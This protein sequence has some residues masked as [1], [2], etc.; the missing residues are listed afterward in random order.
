MHKLLSQ[1]LPSYRIPSAI[2][3][4]VAAAGISLPATDGIFRR[5]AVVGPMMSTVRGDIIKIEEDHEEK[6]T[7]NRPSKRNMAGE[8]STKFSNVKLRKIV[9]DDSDHEEAWDVLE[10]FSLKEHSQINQEHVTLTSREKKHDKL[11]SF[12]LKH[13]H[14]SKF[15]RNTDEIRSRD[16]VTSR[17]QLTKDFRKLDSSSMKPKAFT[18]RNVFKVSPI[19]KDNILLCTPN[20]FGPGTSH[21]KQETMKHT[22]FP[23]PVPTSIL[24]PKTLSL[25][26]QTPSRDIASS[27]KPSSSSYLSP[28]SQDDLLQFTQIRSWIP[29]SF[30]K[31][32][33]SEQVSKASSL[34]FSVMSYNVLAQNLLE[35]HPYL[36]RDCPRAALGWPY[37]W[38]GIK[39]EILDMQPDIVCL[40]EVQFKNPNHFQSQYEPF[41]DSL[42]YKFALKTRTGSKDDGCVIFYKG[43]VFNLEETSGLEYKIDRISLLDRDN[44]GLVCRLVPLSSPTT[45][46]VIGTT[47]LLYNP[48]R[49]D[50][51]LCQ[52]A[53]F[54][55]ELDRLARTSA[56]SYL[57]TIATG[58]FNSDPLSPVERLLST[59]SFHYEG[60]RSGTH[61][62]PRKLLPDSLGLSDSCQWEVELEQRGLGGQFRTGS[63]GFK[64]E[65]GLRS[66]YPTSTGV[67]TFQDRWTMVDYIMYSTDQARQAESQLKLVARLGLPTEKN[68]QRSRKIPSHICPSDH[69][70]LMANFLLSP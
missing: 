23:L 25:H 55:A 36:Y 8:N 29:T 66:V 7:T 15:E 44:I 43:T 12:L 63:G 35:F 4:A 14:D 20:D 56:G 65:F 10:E 41:F 22:H 27:T 13:D 39:R 58:D 53:M 57:P 3:T 42:G 62:M 24:N 64:H 1:C 59:G 51:R 31:A 32:L 49:A 52:T 50:I 28:R 60:L 45:P 17:P 46:L 30:G 34:Q 68:M 47:H 5:T 54:L 19:R 16:I 40:Q 33:N 37:R 2:Y 18:G 48:K 21:G 67:T 9:D 70:P 69:L 11:K 26:Q 61:S 6:N 38:Q